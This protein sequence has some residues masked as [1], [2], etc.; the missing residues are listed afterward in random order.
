M[1]QVLNHLQFIDKEGSEVNPIDYSWNVLAPKY[2]WANSRLFFG[3]VGALDW[4]AIAENLRCKPYVPD[5]CPIAFD[6]ERE[7]CHI[8]FP[9]SELIDNPSQAALD[10]RVKVLDLALATRPDCPSG[11]YSFATP[12]YWWLY[13]NDEDRAK[14]RR[15]MEFS[16][17]V[18]RRQS[19]IIPQVY[20][21]QPF[22]LDQTCEWIY[23]EF[24]MLNELYPYHEI[25]PEYSP[26]WY[27]E[28]NRA[29]Y[30]E[31]D[32]HWCSHV[33][34]K[35]AIPDAEQREY[36]RVFKSCGVTRIAA[37][38][39]GYCPWSLAEKAMQPIIDWVK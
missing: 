6:L 17:P 36:L 18:I 31:K 37:Y 14:M 8:H 1:Y 24:K 22:G 34:D 39:A 23:Q 10:L 3:G 13:S 4:N 28:M 21:P 9:K 33:I 29:E 26:Y 20:I 11:F 5:G 27:E 19:F 16:A 25:I 12:D 32:F 38:V 7:D 2:G 15:L 30:W 35:I